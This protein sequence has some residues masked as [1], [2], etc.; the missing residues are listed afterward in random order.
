MAGALL[1]LLALVAGR[2]QGEPE[3]LRG[4][5]IVHDGDTLSIMDRRLRLRGIDAP[6]L[7]QTC[8]RGDDV[9]PCGRRAREALQALVEGRPLVCEWR[10]RDRYGRSLAV[11]KAGD[12]E[13]NGELVETGWAV[14]FGAYEGQQQRAKDAGLGLWAGEFESPRSWRD[15]H[16]GMA[17]GE[18]F[19]GIVAKVLDWLR[20]Y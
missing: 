17:E 13:V 8:R 15:R 14:A 9:Y 11:C 12:T 19:Q 10:E 2:M 7:S 6:E 20:F 3:R 1:F 18:H 5:A 16:G 4:A